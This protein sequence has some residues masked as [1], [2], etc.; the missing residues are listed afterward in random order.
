MKKILIVDDEIDVRELLVEYFSLAGFSAE[1]AAN[2]QEGLKVFFKFMPD[3]ALVDIQMPVMDGISFSKE[4]F[5]TNPKFPLVMMTGFF[6]DYDIEDILNSG[7]KEVIFKP[8]TLH[9][10]GA[11]IKKYL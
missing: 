4:I 2:G 1:G 9:E 6:K 11:T 5:K 7:V 8:L 10:V 3:I